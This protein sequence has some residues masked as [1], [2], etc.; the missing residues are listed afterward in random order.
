MNNLASALSV[1]GNVQGARELH[2]AELEVSRRVR[3]EEHPDTLTS[4]HNLCRLQDESEGMEVDRRMVEE[5]LAG[6]CKLPAG[7][8]IRA[9]AEERWGDDERR[10]Q[11]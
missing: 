6:V 4:M 2:E 8:P 7:T 10:S 1:L 3:G 11:E 5:L 9:A